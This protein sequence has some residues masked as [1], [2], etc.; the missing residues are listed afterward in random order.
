MDWRFLDILY[1]P[2]IN[3][4]TVTDTL[5]NWVETKYS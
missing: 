5:W 4:N 3:N 2:Q 1:V